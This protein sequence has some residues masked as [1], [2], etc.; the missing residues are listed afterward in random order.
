[1]AGE[2][3]VG[4]KSLMAENAMS[5][6]FFS[7]IVLLHGWRLYEVIYHM[8]KSKKE[9]LEDSNYS[10]KY[11]SFFYIFLFNNLNNINSFLI[12]TKKNIKKFFWESLVPPV[13]ISNVS[14]QE[15]KSDLFKFSSNLNFVT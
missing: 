6:F 14:Y 10:S 2:N 9:T 1:M 11:R 12:L 15:N 5:H 4:L 8:I 3:S 13:I 7:K